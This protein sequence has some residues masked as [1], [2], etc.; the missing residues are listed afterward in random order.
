MPTLKPND[1]EQNKALVGAGRDVRER[2]LFHDLDG[3]H[4]SLRSTAMPALDIAEAWKRVDQGHLNLV[5]RLIGNFM[6]MDNVDDVQA[7]PQD[8]PNAGHLER[9]GILILGALRRFSQVAD[10]FLLRHVDNLPAHIVTR[11]LP[12]SL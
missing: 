3:A 2:R 6:A 7:R 1:V 12:L 9:Y 11:G 10:L 4:G 5:D 8:R